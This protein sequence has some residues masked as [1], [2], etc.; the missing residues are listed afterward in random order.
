MTTPPYFV[1]ICLSAIPFSIYLDVNGLDSRYIENPLLMGG[2]KFDMRLYVLVTSYRPLKVK[3][4][5]SQAILSAIL[6]FIVIPNNNTN[7]SF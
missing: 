2:R 6:S 4:L 7:Y 3:R 1:Y 5:F